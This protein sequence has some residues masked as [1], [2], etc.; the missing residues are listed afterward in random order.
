[1]DADDDDL[2]LAADVAHRVDPA[3]DQPLCDLLR[4]FPP[5]GK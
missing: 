1:V 2:D 5:G 3:E 4:I